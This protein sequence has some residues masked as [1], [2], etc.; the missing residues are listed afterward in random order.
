VSLAA[1]RGFAADERRECPL[2]RVEQ[3]YVGSIGKVAF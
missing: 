1:V 2:L 3:T